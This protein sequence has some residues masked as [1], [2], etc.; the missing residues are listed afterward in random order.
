MDRPTVDLRLSRIYRRLWYTIRRPDLDLEE[1][2]EQAEPHVQEAEQLSECSNRNRNFE[3]KIL[4]ASITLDYPRTSRY[5]SIFNRLIRANF[6]PEET[7]SGEEECSVYYALAKGI[8]LPALEQLVN[9]GMDINLGYDGHTALHLA[10]FRKQAKLVELLIAV[11]ADC[12]VID[13][14]GRMALVFWYIPENAYLGEDRPDPDG[15]EY[16][17]NPT[18]K[19]ND[20]IEVCYNF[21]NESVP[22]SA[23]L[24]IRERAPQRLFDETPFDLLRECFLKHTPTEGPARDRAELLLSHIEAEYSRTP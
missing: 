15:Y 18:Y 9:Y 1:R 14:L 19:A 24:A 4:F 23:E 21:A 3:R 2:S 12:T 20:Q 22:Y 16:P 10:A 6:W 7:Q 17:Q 11:H 8:D 5:D 13:A